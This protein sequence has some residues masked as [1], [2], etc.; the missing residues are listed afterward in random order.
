MGFQRKSVSVSVLV[1][2]LVLLA[3]LPEHTVEFD[4]A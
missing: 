3:L 2:Q 1:L 4:K